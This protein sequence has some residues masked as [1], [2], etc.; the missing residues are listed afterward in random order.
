MLHQLPRDPV[1]LRESAVVG[2]A[3]AVASPAMSLLGSLSMFA[4]ISHSVAV[5]FAERAGDKVRDVVP[6]AGPFPIGHSILTIVQVI[7]GQ[8]HDAVLMLQ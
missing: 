7:K 1:E 8:G 5:S 2:L 6:Q 4:I 3:V